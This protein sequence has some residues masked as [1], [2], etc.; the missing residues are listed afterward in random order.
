MFIFLKNVVS[1]RLLSLIT[2]NMF[3]EWFFTASYPS[4]RFST[5]IFFVSF[6]LFSKSIF[7]SLFRPFPFDLEKFSKCHLWNL[8]EKRGKYRMAI[9][10]RCLSSWYWAILFIIGERARERVNVYIRHWTLFSTTRCLLI[11]LSRSKYT[12]DNL[13]IRFSFP[14]AECGRTMRNGSVR[15]ILV[16][17]FWQSNSYQQ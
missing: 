11:L 1:N 2:I 14:W 6:I 17:V 16:K 9:E 12:L 10:M 5:P 15:T 3:F 8:L 7:K 4:Y 13:N